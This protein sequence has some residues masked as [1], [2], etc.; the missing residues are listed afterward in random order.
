M[1][2]EKPQVLLSVAADAVIAGSSDKSEPNAI[3]AVQ[4]LGMTATQAA[5]EADE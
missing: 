1:R 5:Y 2:Y 3:D 4:A